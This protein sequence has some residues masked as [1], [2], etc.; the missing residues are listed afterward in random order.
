MTP[1]R[2]MK[3]MEREHGKTTYPRI[4]R[5]Q[6]NVC[7]LSHAEKI[8]SVGRKYFVLILFFITELMLDDI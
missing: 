7:L 6:K 8:G 1:A 5:Q 3:G 4:L 2:D